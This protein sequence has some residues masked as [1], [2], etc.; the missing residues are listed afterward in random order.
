LIVDACLDLAVV[1]VAAVDAAVLLLMFWL[2][3]MLQLL[4]LFL[5]SCS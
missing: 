2:K 5:S 3:Q 1:V 4:S